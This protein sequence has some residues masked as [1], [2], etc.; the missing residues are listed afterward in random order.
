MN[1][2][3]HMRSFLII[4]IFACSLSAVAQ[5]ADTLLIVSYNVENLFDT[6]D[7]SLTTDEDF[8]PD[9]AYHWTIKKYKEKQQHIAQVI[10]SIGGFNPPAIVGLCEIENRKTVNA[11]C[12]YSS[13]KQ[14]NY[15]Y[16]HKE[17]P[18]KRGI[19]VAMLYQP[20]KFQLI[21]KKFIEVVFPNNDKT[22]TRDIL[23]ASGILPNKD[24]LHVFVCH[25]PSRM[26]G[27]KKSEPKRIFVAELLR[28]KV[29]SI[30]QKSPNANIIIMGDFNDGPA[31]ISIYKSLNAK[32]LEVKPASKSL[33]NLHAI[34]EEKAEGS[35]KFQCHW[36]MLDQIIVS[37]QLLTKSTTFT[38]QNNA[39]I[40]RAAFLLEDD[41]KC[42][43]MKPFRTN[44]GFKYHG[45]YSDHLPVYVKLILNYK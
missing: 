27:Q 34:Y 45:G 44:A 22:K 42:L 4:F 39:G 12:N 2:N 5:Q 15:K 30:Y 37:N 9:G 1:S 19:D 23:Y 40:Y 13:L 35:H 16:I 20:E 31:D 14:L 10:S 43:G 8:M 3:N 41:P 17:S 25:F 32:N 26:G 7:D 38:S 18:D 24:T 29:D 6:D 36:S 28:T 21:N 11:L 33:Y